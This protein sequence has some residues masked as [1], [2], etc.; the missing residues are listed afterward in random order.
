MSKASPPAKV[1]L[2]AVRLIGVGADVYF[3][4]PSKMRTHVPWATLAIPRLLKETWR[5]SHALAKPIHECSLLCWVLV[6]RITWPCF[7]K[8]ILQLEQNTTP[9]GALGKIRYPLWLRTPCLPGG[10]MEPLRPWP[11][12]GWPPTDRLNAA[13][14]A[15]Q[16]VF[17]FCQCDYHNRQK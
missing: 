10:L 16:L 17:F 13:K 3:L 11:T 5:V 1:F 14:V 7:Q 2:A 6:L 15:G 8:L 9:R 4:R 12:S